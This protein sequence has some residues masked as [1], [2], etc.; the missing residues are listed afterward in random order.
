MRYISTQADANHGARHGLHAIRMN[1]NKHRPP[2][3]STADQRGTHTEPQ[4][5]H[6]RRAPPR[7]AAMNWD[8]GDDDDDD[9]VRDD[10]RDTKRARQS[11]VVFLEDDD[12]DESPLQWSCDACTFHNT[13]TFAT[14]CDMCGTARNKVKV[15]SHARSAT[16]NT[17]CS[18]LLLAQAWLPCNSRFLGHTTPHALQHCWPK[19]LSTADLVFAQASQCCAHAAQCNPR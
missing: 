19:G 9:D 11:D 17:T 4:P 7:A 18:P 13:N 2:I 1:K 15:S 12:L 16:P 10:G 8:H 5:A 3:H 6:R 14:H